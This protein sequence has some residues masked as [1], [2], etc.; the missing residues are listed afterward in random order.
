MAGAASNSAPVTRTPSPAE[1]QKSVESHSTDVAGRWITD[2]PR[3][4]SL[5]SP[6]NPTTTTAIVTKPKSDGVS[7]LASTT[8]VSSWTAWRTTWDTEAHRMALPTNVLC[9]AA[10]TLG[11]PGH[12][13][14]SPGPTFRSVRALH[15]M[16]ELLDGRGDGVDDS[17]PTKDSL[18]QTVD[19]VGKHLAPGD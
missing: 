5:N 16:R 2:E 4:R 13:Q 9:G 7:D 14:V 15:Q 18:V 8:I 3:L 17:H 10:S 6:T 19:V 1:S 12:Y 11:L